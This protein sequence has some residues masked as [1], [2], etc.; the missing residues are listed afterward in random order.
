M[1][2][3]PAAQETYDFSSAKKQFSRIGLALVAFYFATEISAFLM[4]LVSLC[5]VDK[6]AYPGWLS[7]LISCVCMYGIGAPI[8][9]LC[10]RGTK[11]ASP[12]RTEVRPATLGILFMIAMALTYVGKILGLFATELFTKLT[13]LYISSAAIELIAELPW[14][15]TLL[16]A[17]VLA[18]LF[19]ELIFRKWIL[20]RTRAY[21][22]KTAILFSALLFG[23][24]H[25]NPEQFFYAFFV[26][27]VLSYL[28]V[29]TGS[30]AVCALLHGIYNFVGGFLPTVLLQHGD[31]EALFSAE[32]LEAATAVVEANLPVY[33]GMMVYSFGLFGIQIAGAVQLFLYRK[34]LHFEEAECKLPRDSEASTAFGNVGVGLFILICILAPIAY[35][36]LEQYL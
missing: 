24:F 32:T 6:E 20:D 4:Q 8:M 10:L 29:R 14:Y 5:F 7:V 30:L 1:D 11:A 33:L 31:L 9:F 28:Y 3:T 17:V 2:Q 22:E 13:G 34:K 16:Y 27:L 26:G 25:M 18:P 21:G 23:L 15:V 12:G 36:M 19:E 35:S